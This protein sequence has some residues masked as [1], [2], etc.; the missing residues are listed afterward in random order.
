MNDNSSPVEGNGE[1]IV[2]AFSGGLDTSYCILA[3][4]EQ[5]YEVQTVFVDTGG[6][7]QAELAWI[8]DRATQLGA[9]TH[10]W[11]LRLATR[12]RLGTAT[13]LLG[14]LQASAT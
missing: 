9:K 12:T 4:R 8:H 2:L 5:G 7:S 3:L 13:H 6:M 14:L 11:G 10:L 1:T